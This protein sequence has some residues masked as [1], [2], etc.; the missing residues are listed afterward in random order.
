MCVFRCNNSQAL[1]WQ[2]AVPLKVKG[3]EGSAHLE[4]QSGKK[5]GEL[6]VEEITWKGEI[7][8]SAA[9]PVCADHQERLF[10]SSQNVGSLTLLTLFTINMSFHMLATA[11]DA[12]ASGEHLEGTIFSLCWTSNKEKSTAAQTIAHVPFKSTAG[13]RLAAHFCHRC[14]QMCVF[15][16]P[17]KLSSLNKRVPDV[18]GL[19]NFT[20]PA[21][22]FVKGEMQ[23]FIKGNPN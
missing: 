7:N 13:T 3:H 16:W 17:K 14:M 18:C 8:I 5:N 15:V 12:A 19:A 21:E 4:L 23:V 10:S 6:M 11:N 2:S 9:L 22:P 1:L 20:R